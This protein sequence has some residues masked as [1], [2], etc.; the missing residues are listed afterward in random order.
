MKCRVRLAGEI[1][2]SK[3]KHQEKKSAA[4]TT[5]PVQSPKSKNNLLTPKKPTQEK[6]WCFRIYFLN[7]SALMRKLSKKRDSVILLSLL[8]FVT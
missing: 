6:E 3:L 7:F 2:K 5:T 4:K 1:H 8:L